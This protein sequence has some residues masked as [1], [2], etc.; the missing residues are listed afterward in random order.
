MRRVKHLLPLLVVLLLVACQSVTPELEA[1]FDLQHR[2]GGFGSSDEHRVRFLP[3]ITKRDP[4]GDFAQGLAIEV[5]IFDLDVRKREAYGAALGPHYATGD[6]ILEQGTK[7]WFNW[8]ALTTQR[9]ARTEYVRVEIRVAGAAPGPVCNTLNPDCLGYLDVRLVSNLGKGAKGTPSGI[10]NVL[11]SSTQ[12]IK[13]KVLAL[14]DVAPPDTLGELGSLGGGNFDESLGNCVASEL[15]RPGQGLQA[16]GAGLQAVGAGLQAVGAVG[17]LFSGPTSSFASDLGSRMTT[18][19]EVANRLVA[20]LSSGRAKHGVSLLVVDDFGGIYDVPA[21][22]LSGRG[23]LVALAESGALSHGSV[24]LHQLKQMAAQAF[25]RMSHQGVNSASGQPYYKYRSSDGPYLAIQVVDVAGLNT[26]DVPG[27]IRA[28]MQFLGGRGPV[29]YQRVVVNMS[30]TV[31]PCSVLSDFG[32]SGLPNFEAYL[33]AIRVAN[34][35]GGQYLAEL[36][37]LVSTPVALAQEAL[38]AYLQCPFPTSDARCDGR[39]PGKHSRSIATSI[40]HVGASGNYGN[41]YSLYPAAWP[42][43]VSVGA[44]D[45][46]GRRFSPERSS[47]SNA[48]GVLAPGGLFLLSDSRGQTTV[49]AGTSFAAP[50]ASLFLALDQMRETPRCEASRLSSLSATTPALALA[51]ELQLPL[52]PAFAPSGASAVG[53]FCSPRR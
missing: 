20:E 5:R 1:E 9:R 44:V 28:A 51:D 13:F 36:D 21:S 24:V 8:H 23:D 42:N 7:Y 19:S 35:I 29:G 47:Y 46:V 52:L 53:S 3:P 49:Y 30:F 39:S 14:P 16:V 26:D 43:V 50:V 27:A 38:F 32:T 2:S 11:K 17:G 37:T 18:T 40:V 25:G 33:E 22:L 6:G 45:V 41:D 10:M 48:A 15:G 31:V 34:G 12:T 4:H